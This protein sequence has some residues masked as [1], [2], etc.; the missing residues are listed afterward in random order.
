[1]LI[2]CLSALLSGGK[3]P[4]TGFQ[5]GKKQGFNRLLNYLLLIQQFDA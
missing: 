2:S 1:M 3:K 4:A 5:H